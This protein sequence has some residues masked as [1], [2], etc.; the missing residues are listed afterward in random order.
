MQEA[1]PPF[2]RLLDLAPDA[3]FLHGPDGRFVYIN[4]AACAILGYG[5]EE[6]L[7]MHPWDFEVNNSREHMLGK[8]AG[9]TPDVPVTVEGLFRRR[10]E[11]TFSAEVRLARFDEGGRDWFVA[12]CRDISPRKKAEDVLR[13][14]ERTR[15][16]REFHDTLA[17][18][19]TAIAVQLEAARQV[20]DA[21]PGAAAPHVGN[22]LRLARESLQE[23]RRSV[24]ALRS[25][26]LENG[27]LAEA[28]R[29]LVGWRSAGRPEKFSF[30]LHG[31]PRPVPG[32]KEP[33]LLRIAQ[34][35]LTNVLKHARAANVLLDLGYTESEVRLAIEDDGT[36]FDPA[37]GLSKGI[38]LTGMEERAEQMGARL[39]LQSSR[40]AGVK[41]VVNPP[42]G[43]TP[44]L[45]GATAP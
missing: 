39:L 15:M 30:R 5:R 45:P 29:Q 23:A 32:D 38:G 34:E 21:E 42:G 18:G 2:R 4:D 31:R 37:A 28:L 1:E 33:H 20:I 17:H 12:F 27:D 3:I 41:L 24:Q 26:V 14:Q 7:S 6:L 13:M 8:W 9:M 19:Q 40:G 11:T 10:D 16:A 35:A 36:G 22:A 43:T 44:P 25:E